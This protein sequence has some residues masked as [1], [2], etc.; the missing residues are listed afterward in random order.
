M[1]LC[2][3]G[4]NMR[5]HPL[6]VLLV[7]ASVT[8]V[9]ERGEIIKVWTEI[10]PDDPARRTALGRC[11]FENHDFNRF[12][13]A[14]RTI[15]YQKWIQP[16]SLSAEADPSLLTPNPVDL[17]HAVGQGTATYMPTGDIRKELA[18]ELYLNT[19]H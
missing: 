2:D 4:G 8:G 16:G 18:T 14:A 3:T 6:A 11:Y 7:A 5:V 13:A 1:G 17:A 19:T 10:N 9:V 12:N 15:C